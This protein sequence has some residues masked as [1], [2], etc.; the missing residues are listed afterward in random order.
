MGNYFARFGWGLFVFNV[1]D[2]NRLNTRDSIQ[3]FTICSIFRGFTCWDCRFTQ[4]CN[5]Q[6]KKIRKFS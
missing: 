4:V 1:N 6:S 3:L 2:P 5:V